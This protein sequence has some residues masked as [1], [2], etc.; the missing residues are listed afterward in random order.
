VTDH[1]KLSFGLNLEHQRETFDLDEDDPLDVSR[2]ERDMEWFVA[3]S[4]GEHWSV[5]LDGSV[6]SSTFGNVELGAEAR[7]AVE[8]NFFPY[9]QYASR[10]LRVA[11][12]A[13]PVY[14]RYNEVT[15]F[16]KL[17]E[18]LGRH[19]FSVTLDQR[20][21]WGT[22]QAGVEWSQYLHDF[23]KSRLEVEGEL[24]FRL[25]RGFSIQFEG[26]ASR[27]RDQISLPRRGATP[28]EVL[29]RLR[30]LQSGHEV[31]VSLGGAYSFGS[32]F[33]NIVNPRFGR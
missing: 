19:G 4:L 23:S 11:Y 6:T 12:S 17:R 21:P 29:L 31:R 32:I 18:T 13:G 9:S 2:R 3:K 10:Q 30:Q 20:E 28:E 8:F 1:W 26:S 7:P 25:A 27:I 5:G 16:D 14:S 15:L 22:L 33:N 24:S